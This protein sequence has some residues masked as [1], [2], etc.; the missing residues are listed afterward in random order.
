LKKSSGIHAVRAIVKL[1][2]EPETRELVLAVLKPEFAH[3]NPSRSAVKISSSTGGLDIK[4]KATDLSS[5]RASV[6]SILRLINVV[7]ETQR[8]IKN[9]E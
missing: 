1:Y 9:G 8:I 7:F 6:T 5:F 3:Q 4:V 2:T